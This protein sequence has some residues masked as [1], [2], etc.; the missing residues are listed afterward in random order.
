MPGPDPKEVGT[1]TGDPDIDIDFEDPC[2]EPPGGCPPGEA[3]N[4]IK[5]ECEEINVDVDTIDRPDPPGGPFVPPP[6]G[7][8]DPTPEEVYG[9]I[10]CMDPGAY[11]YDEAATHPCGEWKYVVGG[12]VDGEKREIRP[13]D[14]KQESCCIYP[15][16]FP[17][18]DSPGS[19]EPGDIGFVDAKPSDCPDL[20][21]LLPEEFP[22]QTCFPN[23]DAYVPNWVN[24]TEGEPFLNQRTCEYSIVMLADPPDCSQEYLDSFIPAA[25]GKLLSYYNKQENT[26]F[27]NSAGLEFI[28]SSK[29]A[30]INGVVGYKR[31]ALDFT[32]TAEV[33]T[34]YISPRPLE[35]T[36]ILITVRAEEFNRIPEKEEQFSEAAGSAFGVEPSYVV[37]YTKEILAIFNTVSMSFK[38]YENAYADWCL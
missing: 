19:S 12:A 22:V 33:K 29:D 24:Q 10:G 36:K 21:E 34:F 32:G 37:F 18:P 13:L 16:D 38:H 35:K 7:G 26:T 30:L 15:D 2:Q 17:G 27:I 11:N 28:S 4:D 31:E 6:G 23:Q 20:G 25:V 8:K 14:P 3:W 9:I 1:A 5:C